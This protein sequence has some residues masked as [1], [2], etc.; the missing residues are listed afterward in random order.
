MV[1]IKSLLAASA[2]ALAV[3]APP[4][5]A[6]L[7]VDNVTFTFQIVDSN[8]FTLEIENFLNASGGW[9]GVDS[10]GALAFKDLGS[11]FTVAGST[12]AP[13]SAT[14]SGGEL[15]ANGCAGGDSGGLCF[16]F[17]PLYTVASNDVLF[18]INVAGTLD[19]TVIDNKG[20]I[21]LKVNFD[22]DGTQ[23]GSLVSANFPAGSSSSSSSGGQESSSSGVP[24]PSS[25]ALALLGLGLL[26]ASFF[27]RRARRG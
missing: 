4:A 16:T 27:N 10:I 3:V 14:G 18:T 15:N 13:G 17:D 26:G 2:V 19:T 6:S 22:K 5:H 9:T 11:N 12:I 7:T 23:V 21:H 24:E 20:G 25:S 8:T 1:S